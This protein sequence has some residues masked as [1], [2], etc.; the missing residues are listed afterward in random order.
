M[1]KNPPTNA[2]DRFDPRSGKIPLP[3]GQPSLHATTAEARAPQSPCCVTREAN[4][5]R[6]PK[7]QLERSPLFLL[8]EKPSHSSKDPESSFKKKSLCQK[9]KRASTWPQGLPSL[10]RTCHSLQ[11]WFPL[12]P[13]PAPK[14]PKVF[15]QNISS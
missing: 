10:G 11:M 2:G 12:V 9:V 8:L 4:A 6:S 13:S 3:A 14:H 1:F 7:L 15:N 5:M